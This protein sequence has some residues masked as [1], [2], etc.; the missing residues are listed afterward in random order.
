M[1]QED[2]DLEYHALEVECNRRL[3][4][5]AAHAETMHQEEYAQREDRIENWFS[6]QVDRLDERLM[7]EA[8]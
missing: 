5:L 4:A 3:S 2:Y 1:T 6:R 8:A 7:K